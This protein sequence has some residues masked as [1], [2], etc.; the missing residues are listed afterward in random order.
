M[1]DTNEKYRRYKH[2][3]LT[4]ICTGFYYFYIVFVSMD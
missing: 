3:R 1:R 4:L 2:V